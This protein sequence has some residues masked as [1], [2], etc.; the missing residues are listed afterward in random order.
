MTEKMYYV[1]LH[2]KPLLVTRHN[3][4][5]TMTTQ[6]T[7]AWKDLE[8]LVGQPVDPRQIA[9]QHRWRAAATTSGYGD[10]LV[11]EL[12]TTLTPIG[13]FSTKDDIVRA[14]VVGL[15]EHGVL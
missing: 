7:E 1:S 3:L 6:V 12:T 10:H 14:L 5:D 11:T 8:A 2:V 4:L 13:Q 15:A 9:W